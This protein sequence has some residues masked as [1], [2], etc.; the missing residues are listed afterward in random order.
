MGLNQIPEEKKVPSDQDEIVR[1]YY[2]GRMKLE[3]IPEASSQL[4]ATNTIAPQRQIHSNSLLPLEEFG[5]ALKKVRTIDGEALTIDKNND[6]LPDFE[7]SK[8]NQR[9]SGAFCFQ[10]ELLDKRES[11]SSQK[12]REKPFKKTKNGVSDD[13][14]S[15]SNSLM[16]NVDQEPKRLTPV[17]RSI[18][19][20][21]KSANKESS[22]PQSKKEKGRLSPCKCYLAKRVHV[23]LGTERKENNEKASLAALKKEE[24]VYISNGLVES[25]F[26]A[27]DEETKEI[28]QLLKEKNIQPVSKS[29]RNSK[30]S[31]E[32]NSSFGS[33]EPSLNG[34]SKEDFVIFSRFKKQESHSFGLVVNEFAESLDKVQETKGPAL[35]QQFQS[36]REEI[37]ESKE[38][39]ESQEKANDFPLETPKKQEALLEN[40]ENTDSNASSEKRESISRSVEKVIDPN[41]NGN[42]NFFVFQ[43]D[44]K[45]A[46]KHGNK[47][48]FSPIR[49]I[50]NADLSKAIE[51]VRTI[52]EIDSDPIYFPKS[53]T[54]KVKKLF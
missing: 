48:G 19:I 46:K 1:E 7:N 54:Q 29:R 26:D 49:D 37:P 10:F 51:D 42:G 45:F 4:E 18:R 53:A 13:E 15:N 34:N 39:R 44:E 33:N 27:A 14:K 8:P 30:T 5:P 21:E 16:E 22:T 50:P 43:M 6:V 28:Q 9:R 12:R 47:V 31:S 35:N 52:L 23:S 40:Q 11:I 41:W 36:S 2:P 20:K 25:L 24:F 32:L 3:I 38:T 17:R